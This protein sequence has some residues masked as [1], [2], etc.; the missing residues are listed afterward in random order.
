VGVLVQT[1][2][3]AI[4]KTQGA[5][6]K[7]KFGILMIALAMALVVLSVGSVFPGSMLPFPGVAVA[8]DA[9]K[10]EFEDICSK[11]QDSMSLTADELKS[12][13]SR[14]DALKP[15]LEKLDETQKKVYLKRLQ[16][17]RDLFAF[18]LES[19]EGK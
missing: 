14:C 8:Q 3:G 7:N 9:W 4:L 11:T 6:M 13:V 15:R 17:C 5:I 1:A 18:V 16:M 10:K 2:Y 19:K 12:L